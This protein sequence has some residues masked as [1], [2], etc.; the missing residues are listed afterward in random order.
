M[1]R[2]SRAQLEKSL[3]DYKDS[4]EA[5]K[6]K[7]SDTVTENTLKYNPSTGRLEYSMPDDLNENQFNENLETNQPKDKVFMKYEISKLHTWK[8]L[9]G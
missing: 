2:I 4:L 9:C 8:G 5:S 1:A 3:Q 7:G 6:D